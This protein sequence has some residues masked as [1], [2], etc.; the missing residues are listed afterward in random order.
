MPGG[1][2]PPTRS[3]KIAGFITFA[4][5]A[6]RR[7]GILHRLADGPPDP[8][9]DDRAPDRSDHALVALTDLRADDRANRASQH[10]ADDFTVALDFARLR[11][12]GDGARQRL[13]PLHHHTLRKSDAAAIAALLDLGS[14]AAVVVLILVAA[15]RVAELVSILL[16]G[17]LELRIRRGI[18]RFALAVPP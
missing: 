3:L 17:I 18:A 12:W 2:R 15:A 6:P 4:P 7:A 11:L 16:G 9:A 8:R 5:H 13:A 14:A 1:V 10:G